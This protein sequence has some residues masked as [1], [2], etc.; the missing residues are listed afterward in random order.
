MAEN[1]TKFKLTFLS[2]LLQSLLLQKYGLC[3]ET[4][5]ASNLLQISVSVESDNFS[6]LLSL[7]QKTNNIVIPLAINSLEWSQH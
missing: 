1:S 2:P 7:F 5:E 6:Q 3:A 4:L